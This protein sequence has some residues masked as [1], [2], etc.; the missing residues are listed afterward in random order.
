VKDRKKFYTLSNIKRV[1][2]ELDDTLFSGFIQIMIFDAL[3]GETDRHEENWGILKYRNTYKISPLY[4][5]GCNLLREFKDE[6]FAEEKGKNLDNYIQ[7]S[8]TCICKESGGKY[9]HFELVKMLNQDYFEIV[10]QNLLKI[11]NLTDEKIHNIVNLIPENL[12]TIKHRNY[13]IMYLIKRRDILL[14][15]IK[16]SDKNE[17]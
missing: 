9:K 2:D 10:Q 17:K 14:A 4:D 3:V 5:N 16:V 11:K 1:L 8:T 13:I 15:M 6:K 12:L 7:K